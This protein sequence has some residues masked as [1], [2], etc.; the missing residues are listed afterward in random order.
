MSN[1]VVGNAQIA[2]K[3]NATTQFPGAI[4]KVEADAVDNLAE[5]FNAKSHKFP[6]NVDDNIFTDI[7]PAGILTAPGS[8]IGRGVNKIKREE[9]FK[10]EVK[11]ASNVL[12]LI[13]GDKF[14]A[15]S[16]LKDISPQV[17]NLLEIIEGPRLG[18]YAAQSSPNDGRQYGAPPFPTKKDPLPNKGNPFSEYTD[19][20]KIAPSSPISRVYQVNSGGALKVAYPALDDLPVHDNEWN[21]IHGSDEL[22]REVS[23]T[24]VN[25]PSNV[26]TLKR[27]FKR[28]SFLSDF[29]LKRY[30]H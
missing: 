6:K 9:P 21:A 5:L 10:D 13:P 23:S 27:Q 7:N 28:P 1:R 8:L 4:E 17:N 29:F 2:S 16:A 20:G 22:E 12:D 3:P 14:P 15:Y 25:T 24:T 26:P 11:V 18:D 19:Y 30:G